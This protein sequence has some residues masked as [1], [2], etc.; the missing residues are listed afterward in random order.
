MY[1]YARSEYHAQPTKM[2]FDEIFDLTA[3]VYIN[4]YDK[5]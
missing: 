4:I 3:A 2:T 1:A 5:I